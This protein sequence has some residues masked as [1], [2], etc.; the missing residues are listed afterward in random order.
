MRARIRGRGG[1]LMLAAL[2]AS[3]APLGPEYRRPAA[4][5]PKAFVESGP[6]K[7]AATGTPLGAGRW[8]EIFGD[9]V[10]D[11]L[12][13][14]A[15]GSSP[16]LRAALAR[17]RQARAV[18]GIADSLLYPELGIAPGASRF[19]DSGNRPDQPS[20][21]PANVRYQTDEFHVAL[22]SSYEVDLWGRLRREG[23][24]AL[25]RAQ[26]SEA[27]Y[28]TVLLTLQ[29]DVAQTYFLVRSTDEE[30]RILA[31]NIALMGKS[32]DVVAA[33]YRGGFASDLDLARAE[34]DLAALQASS[35]AAR[36]R[37]AQLQ[38]RLAALVGQLPEQFSLGEGTLTA[39]VPEV[40]AGLPSELLE[41]R[42]DIVRAERLLRASNAGIGIARAAWFPSI[43]L[44][45]A[46]GYQSYEMG[47]LLNPASAL[48]MAGVSLW[49]P[50]FD[51]GRIGLDVARAR[52]A[53]DEALATYREHI[54]G[55]FQEVESSLAALR[56]LH[57]Q[58]RFE[59]LAMD[60][61]GRATRLAT[62]RY[63]NGLVALI[64][65][66][67]AQRTSLRA[68]Q[69]AL[70][71]ASDRLLTTVALVKALGGGWSGSVIAQSQAPAA[72]QAAG[73]VP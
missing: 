3:C 31:S 15:M 17:L 39:I 66:I 49:A 11:G 16:G 52:A 54:L 6:W 28:R 57:S 46:A 45:G 63:R 27:D 25:A 50:L 34:A 33:R 41:R 44:T 7:P 59:A 42:P 1:L 38:H 26:A 12:E 43:R 69:D 72:R 14:S 5:T 10:L 23:E 56:Y 35:E 73:S 40:P 37:R 22:Y 47:Q 62:A 55:A 58:A 61:A 67:D 8:W 30:I 24:A 4:A 68:E 20:K 21:V 53:Y 70:A 64:E 29:G 71:V 18:A 51:A 19:G 48:W 65:V 9:P 2:L 36:R 60:H 32:R 13:T